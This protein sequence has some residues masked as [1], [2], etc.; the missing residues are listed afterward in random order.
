[1]CYHFKLTIKLRPSI[2]LQGADCKASASSL[3]KLGVSSFQTASFAVSWNKPML[4]FGKKQ[5]FIR[6]G[7][8]FFWGYVILQHNS[9]FRS[10]PTYELK[11]TPK[12]SWN[13]VLPL[14]IF[15][16]LRCGLGRQVGDMVFGL[17]GLIL[18]RL[19]TELSNQTG[20]FWLWHGDGGRVPPRNLRRANFA[21]HTEWIWAIKRNN[22]RGCKE[23]ILKKNAKK[24]TF[25]HLEIH[26]NLYDGKC[27]HFTAS[28]ISFEIE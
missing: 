20:K 5:C 1:M 26:S 4:L 22:K 12:V 15:S 25:Y 3:S 17:T 23:M 19:V 7:H 6:F 13:K 24:I 14:K 16:S 2:T 10:Y 8:V 28:F 18:V 21:F 11:N 27:S 9:I